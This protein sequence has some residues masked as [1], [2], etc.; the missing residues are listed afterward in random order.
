MRM[1]HVYTRGVLGTSWQELHLT[2]K[3]SIPCRV[4]GTCTTCWLQLAESFVFTGSVG[5]L[6]DFLVDVYSWQG[7]HIVLC[8]DVR[9]DR[10]RNLTPGAAMYKNE[11]HA[12]PLGKGLQTVN[13]QSIGPAME[14]AFIAV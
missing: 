7:V 13:S 4:L 2:V 9:R 12:V 10:P 8:N 5:H 11:V 14:L 1:T 3:F 6:H